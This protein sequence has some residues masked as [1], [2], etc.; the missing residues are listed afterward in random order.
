MV[1]WQKRNLIRQNTFVSLLLFYQH[2][3]I[4]NRQLQDILTPWDGSILPIIKFRNVPDCVRVAWS[5]QDVLSSLYFVK[6]DYWGGL[7]F[8]FGGKKV[9][10]GLV[11]VLFDWGDFIG[12]CLIGDFLQWRQF[13]VGNGSITTVGQHDW[14]GVLVVGRSIEMPFVQR[15][16]FERVTMRRMRNVR[17]EFQVKPVLQF[18][19]LNVHFIK[20]YLLSFIIRNLLPY[21]NSK[22]I[23]ML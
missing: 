15:N 12:C 13:K 4:I 20:T 17:L 16:L 19:L 10:N 6:S 9:H 3:F 18:L 23:I 1:R 8:F 2:R 7:E 22:M 11:L 21:S 14:L 5:V